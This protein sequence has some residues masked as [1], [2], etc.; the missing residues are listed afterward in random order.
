M[1][2]ISGGAREVAGDL[3]MLLRYNA[4]CNVRMFDALEALPAGEATK[5]RPTRFRNMVHTMN[6]IYVIDDIFKA[7]LQGRKHGYTS[8][9]TEREPSLAELR[10]KKI[11][12]DQWYLAQVQLW[13]RSDLAEPVAFEYVGGGA[14]LMT[15]R[16]IIFHIINHG[17]YHR[18][19]VADMLYQVPVKPPVSDITVYVRDVVR[20]G[21]DTP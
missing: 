10:E 7:H 19:I 15:R 9:N 20:A 16:E 13:S 1:D 14:G 11:A 8:R 3:A 21:A 18:G 6:H 4:W 12:I 2:S 17:T 5:E